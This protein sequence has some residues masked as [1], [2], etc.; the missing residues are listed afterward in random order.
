MAFGK[1]RSKNSR[2]RAKKK[3]RLNPADI[4]YKNVRFLKGFITERGKIVPRRISGVSA[5]S[6]RRLTLAIRRARQLALLP[7]TSMHHGR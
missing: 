7:Y 2:V 4:D 6:Q 1:K 5:L 3:Q